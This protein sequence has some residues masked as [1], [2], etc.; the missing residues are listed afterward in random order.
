MV[1]DDGS[2]TADKAQSSAMSGLEVKTAPLRPQNAPRVGAVARPFAARPSCVWVFRRVST[3]LLK[4]FKGKRAGGWCKL[5]D[6]K[7]FGDCLAFGQ[8]APGMS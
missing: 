6:A 8:I 1:F 7:A 5:T 4:L 2:M 3:N